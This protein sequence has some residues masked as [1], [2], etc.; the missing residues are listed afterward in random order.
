MVNGDANGILTEAGLVPVSV[1]TGETTLTIGL[2]A[3]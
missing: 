3:E 1:V 2:R